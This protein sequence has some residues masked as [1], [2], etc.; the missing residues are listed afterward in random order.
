MISSMS[1]SRSNRVRTI[2][3]VGDSNLDPTYI[4]GVRDRKHD[5]LIIPSKKEKTVD[6]ILQQWML[7]LSASTT[8]IYCFSYKGF[9]VLRYILIYMSFCMQ[10]TCQK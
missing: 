9:P 4:V 3:D 7:L 1:T 8:I 6:E 2:S 10:M 5:F